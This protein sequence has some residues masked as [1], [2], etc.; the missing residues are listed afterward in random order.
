MLEI[1]IL[2]YILLDL[3]HDFKILFLELMIKELAMDNKIP[4]KPMENKMKLNFCILSIICAIVILPIDQTVN[5]SNYMD[6]RSR[7][8]LSCYSEIAS[9]FE[10][11][12]TYTPS[13]VDPK[14]P[15]VKKLITNL[16]NFYHEKTNL[17]INAFDSE[18]SKLIEPYGKEFSEKYNATIPESLKE[19][20]RTMAGE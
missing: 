7:T 4:Q 13:T 18:D 6:I 1:T 11:S 10:L 9:F 17:W 5:A 15:Q 3:A 20:F 8:F 14:D 16:C 19:A 2:Y 12:L